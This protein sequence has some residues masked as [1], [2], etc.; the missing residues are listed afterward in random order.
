MPQCAEG[1][2]LVFFITLMRHCLTERWPVRFLQNKSFYSWACRK[3]SINRIGRYI[4]ASRT[5]TLPKKPLQSLFNFQAKSRFEMLQY[6]VL[7]CW[8]HLLDMYKSRNFCFGEASQVMSRSSG[9]SS[10]L[11]KSWVRRFQSFIAYAVQGKRFAL[12]L[13]T[14]VE[15][16]GEYDHVDYFSD[17]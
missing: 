6:N 3:D 1:D 16:Q 2:E 14:G 15:F 12:K 10:K 13:V 8:C 4:G 9:A 17:H 7:F 11:R 5:W